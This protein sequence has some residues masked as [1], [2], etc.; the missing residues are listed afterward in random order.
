[1]WMLGIPLAVLMD[2]VLDILPPVTVILIVMTS[3]TAVVTLTKYALQVSF[4]AATVSK[5]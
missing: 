3:V 4:V 1:M 5:Q 2:S